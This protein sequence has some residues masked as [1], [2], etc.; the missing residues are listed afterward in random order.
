MMDLGPVF[1]TWIDQI[2][3]AQFAITFLKGYKSNSM[4][5][6]RGMRQGCALSPLLFNWVIEV[7]A[8]MVCTSP[9]SSGVRTSMRMHKF[10]RLMTSLYCNKTQL[11]P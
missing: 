3:S 8:L 7:L 11:N 4:R 10:F 6:R 1:K 9:A 5:E 2:Y